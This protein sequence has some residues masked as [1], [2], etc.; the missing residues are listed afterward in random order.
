[1]FLPCLR[2]V[3]ILSGRSRGRRVI[4]PARL[5]RSQKLAVHVL[6]PDSEVRVTVGSPRGPI[7]PF[8]PGAWPG[9]WDA[10]C[11]APSAACCGSAST[12][13]LE[14]SGR[15]PKVGP[16][17]RFRDRGLALSQRNGRSLRCQ[18]FSGDRFSGVRKHAEMLRGVCLILAGVDCPRVARSLSEAAPAGAQS[19]GQPR[20]LAGSKT[21]CQSASTYRATGQSRLRVSG[22]MRDA[23]SVPARPSRGMNTPWSDR[24]GPLEVCASGAPLR[25][26][27]AQQRARHRGD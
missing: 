25:A 17:E 19:L 12:E 9:S 20:T 18:R 13:V 22:C 24:R 10:L 23:K 6:P 15:R 14:L 2:E 8:F 7:A 11:L 4:V 21:A 3:A 16:R 27:T 26:T 1:M 5:R